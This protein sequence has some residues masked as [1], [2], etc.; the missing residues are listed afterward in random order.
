MNKVFKHGCFGM[1]SENEYIHTL[2]FGVQIREE[3]VSIGQLI[4]YIN[5]HKD[6]KVDWGMFK[7]M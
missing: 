1:Y 3:S 7:E 2:K 6:K 4:K 5:G